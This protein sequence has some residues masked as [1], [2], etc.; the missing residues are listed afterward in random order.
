MT[1]FILNQRPMR[2]KNSASPAD[3]DDP[4]IDPPVF[5]ARM[6]FGRRVMRSLR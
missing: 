2:Q 3:A 6:R 1:M 4:V 5:I